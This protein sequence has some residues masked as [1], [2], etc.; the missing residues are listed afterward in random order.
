MTT[1]KA[2]KK[3]DVGLT[4]QLFDGG[5]SVTLTN[6]KVSVKIGEAEAIEK[7]FASITVEHHDWDANKNEANARVNLELGSADEEIASGTTVVLQIL[8]G[9]VSDSSKVDG[10][11]FALQQDGKNNEWDM[12]TAATSKAFAE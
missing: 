1:S 2:V 10:I 8:E 7:T 11:T 9:T 6:V 5:S 4:F 12:L 3:D